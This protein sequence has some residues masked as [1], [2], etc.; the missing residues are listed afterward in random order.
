[1]DSGFAAGFLRLM[2]PDQAGLVLANM[3][4]EKAYLVSIKLATMN[5]DVRTMDPPANGG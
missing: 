2:V 1:M 5:D 3:E 4:A